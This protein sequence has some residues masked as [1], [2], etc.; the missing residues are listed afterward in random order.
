M[1]VPAIV[2]QQPERTPRFLFA[3]GPTWNRGLTGLHV[4]AE[5]PF[6]RH[7]WISLRVEG[8]GR[9]TPTQAFSQP[10][11]LYG[12]GSHVQGTWQYA[13]LNFGV[14]ATVTPV[15]RGRVAPYLLFGVAALQAWTNGQTYYTNP[16]GGLAYMNPPGSA[17]RGEIASLW[18]LGTRVRLNDRT[19]QIELRT[20]G[21]RRDLAIG[22]SLRF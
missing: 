1:L 6:L 17:T 14:A 16:Q 2:A 15:S 7:T 20:S 10:S 3:V 5:Y 22:S 9:W 4:R 13:D 18:G 11:I 8:G 21:A 12:D 19:I